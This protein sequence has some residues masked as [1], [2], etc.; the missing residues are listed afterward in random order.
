[1][2]MIYSFSIQN[3][4]F[5]RTCLPIIRY[6]MIVR[7]CFLIEAHWRK[8]TRRIDRVEGILISRKQTILFRFFRSLKPPTQARMQPFT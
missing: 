6:L 7:M 1:M 4:C 5:D 2:F 8:S 3:N